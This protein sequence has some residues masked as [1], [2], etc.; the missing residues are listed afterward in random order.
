MEN[1]YCYY[2]YKQNEAH[3]KIY[4]AFEKRNLFN[5]KDEK[6]REKVMKAYNF[7]IRFYDF[8]QKIFF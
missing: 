2:Y 5:I 7:C 3:D 8:M 4:K 6:K 1:K